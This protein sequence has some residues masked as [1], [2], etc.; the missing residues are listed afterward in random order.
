MQGWLPDYDEN[1][2]ES[3]KSALRRL[4]QLVFTHVALRDLRGDAKLSEVVTSMSLLADYC[5]NLALFT[6][7]R[8]LA[9]RF[10]EPLDSE[11]QPQ[12]MIVI[13]MGKLGGGELN[14]S[15][16]VDF[17]FVYPE[18]GETSGQQHS[19]DNH[20]F[21]TRLG[22]QLIA[23][24]DEVSADGRVFRVDMRLRPNGD[25]GPLAISLSALE[26]Y[27]ITHGREWERYAWIKA[28]PLNAGDN[29]Q[30]KWLLALAEVVRPFVYRRY[31]DF[32]TINAMRDLHS[33]IRHEVRKKGMADH[34]KLGPGGIRE[35]EFI[36]QVFQLI[37]GG[38]ESSLQ[39]RPTLTVL[40]HL[41]AQGLITQQS[42]ADLG[43]A[44]IFLRRLE[45]RL[46]YVE[47][48]Q[49]HRLPATHEAQASL[50]ASMGLENWTTLVAELDRHRN[51]VKANFE[52]VFADPEEGEHPMAV[53]WN[54]HCDDAEATDRLVEYGFRAPHET[55]RRLE[56]LRQSSR[57][58]QLPLANRERLDAVGPRLIAAAAETPEPD[59][60]LSRCLDLLESISRRGAYLA[61]LQQYPQA[62]KKVADMAA[63][64]SWA[65]QFLRQHPILLDELLDAR[66]LQQSPDWS[67]FAKM[68]QGQLQQASDDPERQ[69][70]ILREA[71]HG[72]LF[73]ILAR[74]LAGLTSVEHISDQLSELADLML[75]ATLD[76]CWQ[77]I[78]KRHNEHL[79]ILDDPRFIIVGYGKLGGKELGYIS[80]LDLVFLYD[81]PHP[82]AAESYAR[83][84]QRMSTWL[85][86]TTSAGILFETDLRLRPNGD[87]GIL[88]NNLQSFCQYQMEN[89]WIWEHQALSRARAVAGDPKIAAAFEEI[90]RQVL[91][92]PRNKEELR[93]E[94]L[95]MRDKMRANLGSSAEASASGAFDIK[96]DAG[97]LIDVE[98]VVQYLVLAYGSRHP[99][100]LDNTGN[101]ALLGIIGE[102][103][104]IPAQ[105]AA[106]AAAAYRNYRRL[107]HLARL[108][109]SAPPLQ[110][111]ALSADI[112][113]VTALWHIV[114]EVSKGH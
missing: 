20:D 95:K 2:A 37:R 91:S 102:L 75:Q 97:G 18:S 85:S 62:L 100:L 27:F 21:F 6:L 32:G 87:A 73:R 107:Q 89:A 29:A 103:E 88:A 48:Q 105:S 5:V 111:E 59:L 46:Q 51:L 43:A 52:A 98:F 77:Q 79:D 35:I 44:Y 26:N 10:G 94:I 4:R 96:H 99:Q 82:L 33:Q 23:A 110:C 78:K 101:I 112:E 8:Q 19:T 45:H 74:D 83:L 106:A 50:A 56:M 17:V 60:T 15:S 54:G 40:E 12:R 113:V 3:L 84:A 92:Q 7:H 68:V 47:D 80:D 109:P 72:Q 39:T 63:S 24:L 31:L 65:A 41:G 90:R 9:A 22:K 13:G 104:L 64:S 71:H 11:G 14:V 55:A 16:D 30:P 38:R 57:Y 108:N 25:S 67:A 42:A 114:F 86:C 66:L 93:T 49:T 81:D 53:L 61:L 28:R 70:D 34:I 58:Q 69:M 76:C 1:D 36:A